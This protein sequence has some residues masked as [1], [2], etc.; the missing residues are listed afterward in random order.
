MRLRLRGAGAETQM[1][2]NALSILSDDRALVKRLV[3]KV[4]VM[5]YNDGVD[6]SSVLDNCSLTDINADIHDD[7]VDDPMWL[8]YGL[9]LCW[10]D[11]DADDSHDEDENDDYFDTDEWNEGDVHIGAITYWNDDSNYGVVAVMDDYSAS[12]FEDMSSG[13]IFCHGSN[14]VDG[15]E[16]TLDVGDSVQ[17][18]VAWDSL[19]NR[20]QAVDIKRASLDEI[21]AY[22]EVHGLEPDVSVCHHTVMQAWLYSLEAIACHAGWALD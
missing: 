14:F 9:R 15:D 12:A 16:C 5:S 17:F 8:S 19:R 3:R 1:Q 21:T 7:D 2:L 10:A 18:T 13:E 22:A 6:L 11:T 20:W 4:L